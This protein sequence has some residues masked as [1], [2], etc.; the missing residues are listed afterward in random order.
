MTDIRN[1][2]RSESSMDIYDE[3]KAVDALQE[4][5][6]EKDDMYQDDTDFRA[7]M[8]LANSMGLAQAII[9]SRN[10]EIETLK[11]ELAYSNSRYIRKSDY[12]REQ[13]EKI[14]D[15]KARRI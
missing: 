8:V 6:Y 14:S 9:A 13:C 1:R 11:E 4:K 3:F 2:F 5:Q 10:S 12:V 15:S 7:R